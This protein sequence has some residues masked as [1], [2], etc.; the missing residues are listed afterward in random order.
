ML[1]NSRLV[2]TG[3]CLLGLAAYWQSMSVLLRLQISRDHAGFD[4]M[5]V[6]DDCSAAYN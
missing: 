3:Y 1:E 5:S 2:C 4:G 6:L